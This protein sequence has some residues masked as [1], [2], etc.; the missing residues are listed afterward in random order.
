MSRTIRRHLAPALALAALAVTAISRPG[1]AQTAERAFLNQIP[2]TVGPIT[3]PGSPRGAGATRLDGEVA[4][5][6]RTRNLP[7]WD[8][9]PGSS[10]LAQIFEGP[11]IDGERALLG[12]WPVTQPRT[13]GDWAGRSRQSEQRREGA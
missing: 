3:V 6:G 1:L 13:S 7:T 11:V 12:R 10:L 5:L 8:L 2:A 4:L 9:R